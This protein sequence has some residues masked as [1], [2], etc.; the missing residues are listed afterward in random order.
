MILDEDHIRAKIYHSL[1]SLLN[2]DD[3]IPPRTLEVF[4]CEAFGFNH[5]GDG[6]FYADGIKGN[7]QASIKTRMLNPHVLKR[8][9][10]R[11]FQS[12]PNMFLG[13]NQNVKHNKWNYGLEVVQRR[14]ALDFNDEEAT[15]EKIGVSTLSE[16]SK[17]I[18]ES[19][20]KYGTN[21]TQEII[22]VHGYDHT[23]NFY[24]LSIFWKEY[25]HLNPEKIEWKKEGYG[26]SGYINENKISYKI[27][28]R[29]NGNAKREATCFKEYKNVTKYKH[30]VKLKVPIPDPWPF[31]KNT[32]LAEINLKEKNHV[33]ILFSE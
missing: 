1:K 33:S 4:I 7:V 24:L 13:P 12:H 9:E 6:N 29:I 11:H 16:F 30:S 28:E 18:N 5:V 15:A 26:V 20:Q 31:D 14:Q 22:C 10:G 27:A 17:N 2:P 21:Q 8:K 25:E 23:K 3:T 32:T 19:F